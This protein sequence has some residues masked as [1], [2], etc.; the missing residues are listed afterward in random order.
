[1]KDLSKFENI[2]DLLEAAGKSPVASQVLPPSLNPIRTAV[3]AGLRGVG[4]GIKAVITDPQGAANAIK[5]FRQ[6]G[7]AKGVSKFGKLMDAEKRRAIDNYYFKLDFPQGWPKKGSKFEISASEGVYIGT[8]SNFHSNVNRHLVFVVDAKPANKQNETVPIRR[9]VI[10]MS[11]DSRPY[12]SLRS[13]MVSDQ[14]DA[15]FAKNESESGH[16]FVVNFLKTQNS[17]NG[18]FVLSLNKTYRVFVPVENITGQVLEVGSRI[19][20]N[21]I[22]GNHIEGVVRGVEI[23]K[24]VKG[25]SGNPQKVYIVDANFK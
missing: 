7:I 6:D 17:P 13:V 22:H 23:L 24:D 8:V 11:R 5:Q 3:S 20:G 15:G 19:A 18:A 16:S 1:M 25:V 4:R 2:V 14:T 10:E 12:F 9:Y 21:D